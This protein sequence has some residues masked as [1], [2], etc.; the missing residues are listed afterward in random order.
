M[1]AEPLRQGAHASFHFHDHAPALENFRE[2]V[3]AGLSRTEKSIP[4][5]FLYDETG[6]RLFDQICEQPE[7]YPTRTEMR[8]LER[9]AG[10]MAQCAGESVQLIELGSG[11]SQK[12][13]LLLDALASPSAYLPID[14]SREHL[15]AA[16][17]RVATQYPDVEV[18]A[19]CADYCARFTLPELE[20]DGR[21]VAFFPGSTIGNFEPARA[22]EF[23]AHWS[24]LLGSGSYMVVGVDL[25]KPA[26]VLHRAYD[27]AAGVT[28]AFSRNLLVRCN[29]ELGTDFD[30]GAF[31]HVARFVPAH[32]CVEIHLVSREAAEVRIGDQRFSFAA[33]ERLHVEN[34]HKYTTAQFRALAQEA[35]FTPRECWTDPHGFFSVHL[36]AVE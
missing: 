16:A 7:Y 19:I 4:C 17:S 22:R 27:D 26:E 3:I 21:R 18:H 11:S 31:E 2:A 30:P 34:S 1:T 36:L 13:G 12:V 28:A 5:Q 10:D 32:G 33:G 6:S 15:R 25:A 8:I 14:I 29:R 35:G 24:R 23:L 9:H 20:S